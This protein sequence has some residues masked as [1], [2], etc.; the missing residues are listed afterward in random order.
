MTTWFKTRNGLFLAPITLLQY[1]STSDLSLG[2]KQIVAKAVCLVE[3]LKL[4]SG[5]SGWQK[6]AAR[7]ARPGPGMEQFRW[8]ANGLIVSHIKIS[9]LS[10][11]YK[12]G[13]L[14]SE[15]SQTE[16]KWILFS[17]LF[18]WKFRGMCAEGVWTVYQ[19]KKII[20]SADLR[21]SPKPHMQDLSGTNLCEYQSNKLWME[22]IFHSKGCNSKNSPFH[23]LPDHSFKAASMFNLPISQWI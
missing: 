15:L 10:Q 3:W 1:F 7:G 11:S 23:K 12:N 13:R 9:Y 5:I 22:D 18:N 19:H 21:T 6:V 17:F 14:G 2:Y 20:F 4:N 16:Q 8:Q